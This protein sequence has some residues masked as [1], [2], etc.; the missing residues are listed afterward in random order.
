MPSFTDFARKNLKGKHIYFEPMARAVRAD[1][2]I[3]DKILMRRS[4]DQLAKAR[5]VAQT[6]RLAF[7]G[8]TH[9]ASP[10]S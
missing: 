9:Q 1:G 8:A 7:Q 4:Y 2:L 5:Q 6:Q 10:L 3:E